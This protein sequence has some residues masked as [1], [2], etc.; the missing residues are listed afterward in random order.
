MRKTPMF[1]CFVALTLST[2]ARGHDVYS[3]LKQPDTG[4]SCCNSSA[5]HKSGDC[6]PTVGRFRNGQ[7]EAMLEG[8]WTEVPQS[9]ILKDVIL[10]GNA[11]ICGK[12]GQVYCYIP[13]QPET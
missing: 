2:V 5:L 10:D 11:H 3:D 4:G 1:L 8:K 12:A 6:A 13:P 7:W 9:K